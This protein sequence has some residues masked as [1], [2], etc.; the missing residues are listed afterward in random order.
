MSTLFDGEAKGEILQ[1]RD[2]LDGNDPDDRKSAAK[3]VVALMRAGEN[4]QTVFSSMLRCVKTEDIQI[5]RLYSHIYFFVI[6]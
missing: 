5:K 4:V 6:D 2:Q 1:L 3:R